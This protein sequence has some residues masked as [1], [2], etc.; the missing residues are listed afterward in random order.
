MEDHET[1][2]Q[3]KKNEMLLCFTNVAVFHKILV[4]D[5]PLFNLTNITFCLDILLRVY[6]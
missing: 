4:K 6:T 5:Y 3:N 1:I 2:E